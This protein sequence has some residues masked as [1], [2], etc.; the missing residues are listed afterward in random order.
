M[1]S[2]ANT[3][4]EDPRVS[5]IAVAIGAALL[6]AVGFYFGTGLHPLWL[7][8]W[9]API[10]VIAFAYRSRPVA[11][12][13]TA[14]YAFG[15]LNLFAYFRILE[16][17]TAIR[18]LAF[19][20][21]AMIFGAGVAL[22]AAFFRRNRPL[23]AALALPCLWVAFEFAFSFGK[24]GT[25]LNLAY[26]QMNCLPL[27]QIASVTG[28]WGISFFVFLFGSCLAQIILRPRRSVVLLLA[29]ITIA[30]FVFGAIRLRPIHAE[31]QIAIGLVAIDRPLLPDESNA[32]ALIEGYSNSIEAL[33]RQGADTVLLPEKIVTAPNATGG[34]M[35]EAMQNAARRNSVRIIYGVN[36]VA[37]ATRRNVAIILSPQGGLEAD[38]QKHHH[39]T[40]WEDGYQ[41]GTAQTLL[42][43]S[44]PDWGVAICK[45]MDFPRLSRE[46]AKSGAKLLLVPAWDFTVDD[47]FHGRMSVLRGIESGFAIARSA[48]QGRMTISD[49]R[50]RIIVEAPSGRA[51]DAILLHRFTPGSGLT[52][53]ARHGDWF[54]WLDLIALAALLVL[55]RPRRSSR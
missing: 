8:T 3:L 42:R 5:N 28:I 34:P 39:V 15:A 44:H 43:N 38:Y 32:S 20:G 27:I 25:A 46:Y 47:W 11:G 49:D 48:K 10:P 16:V 54:A 51:P 26:S 41:I 29:S 33:A 1:A 53:Y 19:V 55:L 35:F 23:E 18:V 50:G 2:A 52:F 37:G 14:A 30:L 9:L 13:A 24:D 40:G 45:D 7:L 21:P 4:N 12:F 31:S 17:P 22:S 6:S 36:E